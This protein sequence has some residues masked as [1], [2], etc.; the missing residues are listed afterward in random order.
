MNTTKKITLA[1]VLAAM[2][3]VLVMLI[4]FPIFPAAPFL[5]Y[6][7]GDIPILIGTLVMGIP[8]GIIMTIIACLVQGLTVS[9]QSGIYGIIMH[10][11]STGT[12]LI[13]TGFI[14]KK[15]GKF[16]LAAIVGSIGVAVVM[17][18]A[19]LIVTP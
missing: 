3:V 4:H 13:L 17:C 12:L 5:E 16:I 15:T 7:P 9:A 2:A 1:A 14:A 18:I 11:I 6:D 19:N 8:T 10:I